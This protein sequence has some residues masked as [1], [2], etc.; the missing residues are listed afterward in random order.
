MQF[1]FLENL[2]ISLGWTDEEKDSVRTQLHEKKN[3]IKSIDFPIN[4][5]TATHTYRLIEIKRNTTVHSNQVKEAFG[6]WFV[7]DAPFISPMLQET[8]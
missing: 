8:T 3:N 1:W 4:T 7:P 2:I 5:F 6:F